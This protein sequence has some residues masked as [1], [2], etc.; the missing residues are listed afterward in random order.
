MY[1]S[2]LYYLTFLINLFN[3]PFQSIF[4]IN[5]PNQLSQSIYIELV[6]LLAYGILSLWTYIYRKVY[7]YL[8]S[9][10]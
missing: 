2:F 10:L 1:Y 6:A 8:L 3:Q 9:Y 5:F 7:F 4:L